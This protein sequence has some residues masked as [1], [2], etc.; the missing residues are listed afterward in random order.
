MPRILGHVQRVFYPRLYAGASAKRSLVW[1]GDG[2]AVASRD[3]AEGSC[4][5]AQ[6]LAAAALY[7]SPSRLDDAR[8][9]RV[10][11]R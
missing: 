7:E 9:S 4:S 6:T 5:V 1:P 10:G 2:R 3:V 8:G 11:A